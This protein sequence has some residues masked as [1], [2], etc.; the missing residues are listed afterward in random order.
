MS[1]G[2]VLR[3]THRAY[4]QTHIFV[5]QKC[6]HIEKLRS[7]TTSH[8]EAELAREYATKIIEAGFEV[9]G[10][11]TP[12]GFKYDVVCRGFGPEGYVT[13]VAILSASDAALHAYG[14]KEFNT[15]VEIAFDLCYLPHR[16]DHSLPLKKVGELFAEWLGAGQ[17]KR[18]NT[19][20]RYLAD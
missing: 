6:A 9:T 2:K 4:T 20:R 16:N 15:K 1:A 5:F 17:W 18:H 3:P 12:E 19:R 7:P 13:M 11:N 8:E 10:K 14:E